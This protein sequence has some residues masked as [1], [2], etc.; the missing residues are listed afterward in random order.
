M[1]IAYWCVLA[2]LLMP[3]VTVGIAKWSADYDNAAP[4]DWLANRTGHAKRAHAA[5]LNHFE[6]LPGFAAAV[7]IAHLAGAAQGWVDGLAVAYIALRVG[8]TAAYVGNWPTLRS[9]LWIAAL[10]CVI[11]LFIAAAVGR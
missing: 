1:T 4:R 7:I 6:S 2:A 8:Y 9:L 3:Y 5:H 10:A 11:G